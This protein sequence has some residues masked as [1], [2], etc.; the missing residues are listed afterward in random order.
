MHFPADIEGK[1][2]AFVMVPVDYSTDGLGVIRSV[3][4][5]PGR[6]TLPTPSGGLNLSESGNWEETVGYADL[7]GGAV[8]TGINKGMGMMGDLGKQATT[9]GSFVNDYASLAY[10][11]SNFR[12]YTFE[13]TFLPESQQEAVD[14]AS[15]IRYIRQSALPTYKTKFLDFPKMWLVYPVIQ[16]Q[17]G[18]YLQNCVIT[19]V[20]INYTPDGNLKM[21]NTYHPM[22]TTMS[23]TFKEL[24]RASSEDV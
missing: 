3:P 19:D 23:I 11:G 6:I 16:N 14:V 17:I 15:I 22:H 2:E 1:A 8:A 5:S 9:K 24:F 4:N 18:L 7:E 13:W 10:S 20:S 21:F 12:T